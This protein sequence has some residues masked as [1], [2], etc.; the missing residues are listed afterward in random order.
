LNLALDRVNVVVEWIEIHGRA[1]T[2]A[3]LEGMT[4]LLATRDRA[5]RNYIAGSRF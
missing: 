3:L 4:I 2:E 5:S 1:E